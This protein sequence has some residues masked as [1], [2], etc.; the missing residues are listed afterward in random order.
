ME[1]VTEGVLLRNFPIFR[2]FNGSFEHKCI[3]CVV[4]LFLEILI[5]FLLSIFSNIFSTYKHL[6]PVHKVFWCLAGVRAFFGLRAVVVGAV[7]LTDPELWQDF[8]L[9]KTLSSQLFFTSILGFF[10]FEFSLLLISDILFKQRSYALLVHHSISLVGFG[11]GLFWDHGYFLGCIIVTLEMSTPFTCLCWVLI[12]AKLSQ[13][14]IWKANQCILVHLFH[15]RQNLLCVVMYIVARDWWNFYQNMNVVLITSLI[16][17]SVIML[18]G[19]NPYWTYRKTEQLFSKEDWNFMAEQTPIK[20]EVQKQSNYSN[21][22]SNGHARSR[23]SS[24]AKS[25]RNRVDRPKKKSEI[26]NGKKQK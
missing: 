9:S 16:G 23:D 10:L 11:V 25:E 7:I 22:V 13:T 6:R 20:N 3:G 5:F 15:T 2:R 21:G 1:S 14:F 26:R 4:S 12:K 8:V 19:L 17:G 24:P 18:L